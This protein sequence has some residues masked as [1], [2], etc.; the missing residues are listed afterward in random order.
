MCFL[1]LFCVQDVFGN[2]ASQDI[3]V[4]VALDLPD[5]YQSLRRNSTTPQ[6]ARPHFAGDEVWQGDYAIEWSPVLDGRHNLSVM[7]CRPVCEHIVGSPFRVTVLSAPTYGPN[8]TVTGSGTKDGIA[9]SPRVLTIRDTGSGVTHRTVGGE[10]FD[11]SLKGL[12]LGACPIIQD[13]VIRD[14]SCQCTDMHRNNMTQCRMR[15][16]QDQPGPDLSLNIRPD[17][18]CAYRRNIAACEPGCCPNGEPDGCSEFSLPSTHG[19]AAHDAACEVRRCASPAQCRVDM[20]FKQQQGFQDGNIF[21]LFLKTAMEH[22]PQI[23]RVGLESEILYPPDPGPENYNQFIGPYNM[24]RANMNPARE[25]WRGMVQDEELLAFLADLPS[26]PTVRANS[27]QELFYSREKNSVGQ[28]YFMVYTSACGPR[29][30]LEG[31]VD[32]LV[33]PRTVLQFRVAVLPQCVSCA[34]AVLP[35][36][37]YGR[38]ASVPLQFSLP[39][40]WRLLMRCMYIAHRAGAVVMRQADTRG[41]ATSF[42]SLGEAR[43]PLD[44]AQISRVCA[45]SFTPPRARLASQPKL[46]ARNG[47]GWK[48]FGS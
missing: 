38:C 28:P 31:F 10:R 18:T 4:T 12:S 44:A 21:E 46:K 15:L 1:N 43:S 48:F 26:N 20:K 6:T 24:I 47:S 7:L 27:L 32:E 25:S 13:A 34:E 39:R 36:L 35:F 19:M 17:L 42:S 40:K 22:C 8:S 16:L 2:Y 3:N 9:G 41:N 14:V 11:I 23:E 37:G 29:P 33:W 5:V 45:P 30:S